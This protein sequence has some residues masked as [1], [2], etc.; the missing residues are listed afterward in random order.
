[1]ATPELRDFH[2]GRSSLRG[3]QGL[4]QLE[5][6]ADI[7]ILHKFIDDIG[8]DALLQIGGECRDACPPAHSAVFLPGFHQVSGVALKE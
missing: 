3:D 1:M 7:A 5:Q 6:D 4:P 2:G 8:I